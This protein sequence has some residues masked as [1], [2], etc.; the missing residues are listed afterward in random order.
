M[1]PGHTPPGCFARIALRQAGL[2]PERDLE[3][4]VRPPGD[5]GMYLR[6]LQE[7]SIDAAYVGSTMAPEAIAAEYGW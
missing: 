7:G 6:W 2:D 4:V 1:H 5:Y 3:L